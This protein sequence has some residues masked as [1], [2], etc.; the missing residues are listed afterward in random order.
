VSNEDA[1][2]CE[3][4]GAA[5]EV[6]DGEGSPA[7]AKKESPVVVKK[8]SPPP[9]KKEALK[10]SPPAVKKGAVS[11]APAKK[12]PAAAKEA[13]KAM[14]TPKSPRAPAA[15]PK[16]PRPDAAAAKAQ[17]RTFIDKAADQKKKPVTR[18][19]DNSERCPLCQGDIAESAE[20]TIVGGKAWHKACYAQMA[21]DQSSSGEEE[22]EEEVCPECQEAIE[23]GQEKTIISGQEY[24]KWCYQVRSFVLREVV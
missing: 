21:G 5:L 24:H 11:P 15:G 9:V 3:G 7:P 8:T 6:S 18:K 1:K 23:E 12:D 2:F 19:V 16:S 17:A 22:D 13:A 14:L 10:E 4:C 20:K